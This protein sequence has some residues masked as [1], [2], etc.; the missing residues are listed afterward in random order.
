MEKEWEGEY[1]GMGD[2]CGDDECDVHGVVDDVGDFH[3]T[4]FPQTSLLV[5][6]SSCHDRRLDVEVE[7]G[8][9]CLNQEDKDRSLYPEDTQ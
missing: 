7:A 2:E 6:R 9:L 5:P 1:D 8:G 4:K 3:E